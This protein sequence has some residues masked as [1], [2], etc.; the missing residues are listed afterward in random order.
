MNLYS[1]KLTEMTKDNSMNF[2]YSLVFFGIPGLL[3]Y[4]GV[5]YLTPILSLRGIPRIVS[6]TATIWGPIVILF[7]IVFVSFVRKSNRL[8]FKER[9][10]FHKLTNKEWLIALGAFIVVQVLELA[11]SRTGAFFSQFR[12]FSLPEGIPDF[13]NPTFKIADG[14]SQLFGVP[15]K[16]NWWLVLFWLGWLIINIGCEEILWR[17]YALPLQEKYFGKYAWLVNGIC[18]NILIHFFMRWNF[19]VLMPISLI[20]PYLVQKYKNT[21]IGVII[22]GTGNLLFF[23]ILIPGIMAK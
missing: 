7:I 16:G 13:F 19:I 17:G 3:M 14:L 8:T 15:I 6:W 22:H 1:R 12:F 23:V 4:L 9:F 20:T 2:F 18:W 10:R 21:W 5:Y 11:L